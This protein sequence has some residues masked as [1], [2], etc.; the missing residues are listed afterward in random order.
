MFSNNQTNNTDSGTWLDKLGSLFSSPKLKKIL[1]ILGLVLAVA[2][3]VLAFIFF[4]NRNKNGS[5]IVV[6]ENNTE[7]ENQ[8]EN[9]SNNNLPNI[10][11]PDVN[12]GE[13]INGGENGNMD[14]EYLSF[15]DFYQPVSNEIAANINDYNLP[16][17]IKIDG[18]NYYDISRKLNLDLVIDDLNNNGFAVIENPWQNEVSDFYGIYKQL[19]DKQ[20]PFLITSDFII[21]YYQNTIKQTFKGIEESIF[22][23]NLWRINKDLY[24]L[25]KNRYEARLAKVGNVNDAILEGQRMEMAF[26]AVALELLKPS[27]YQIASKGAIEDRTKFTPGD[28]DTFYFNVPPYLRDDVQREVQMIEAAK[29]TAKSPNLLYYRNY[30]DFAVPKEYRGDAKLHNFFLASKWLSSPFP[31]EYKNGTCPDC[32][33][34]QEDWRLSMIAASLISSDFSSRFNLKSS[35]AMIYKLMAYFQGLKEEIDYVDFRDALADV[36]GEDYE[37]EELFDDN[38]KDAVSNLEKLK[39]RLLEYEYAQIMGAV[40]KSKEDNRKLIAFKMLTGA[41]WPNDY[42]FSR[43]TYPAVGS[44][45]GIENY[46]SN[47]TACDRDALIVRCNGFS[48]DIANLVEPISNNEFFERN[49]S[50]DNY[51]REAEILINQLWKDGISHGS[52]YW[53]NINVMETVLNN[54]APMPVFAQSESWQDKNLQTAI[55]AWIN[56]QLPKEDFS[57]NPG[58]NGQNLGKYFNSDQNIYV[59]PN[60]SLIN[61]LIATNNMMEEMFNA[62][63]LDKET[64]L[65]A[66]SIRMIKDDLDMLKAVIEKELK[67]EMI[68]DVDGEDLR[69]FAKKYSIEDPDPND[70]ILRIYFEDV[71]KTVT[72]DLRKPK[73]MVMVHKGGE[74]NMIAVGPVWDYKESR[75]R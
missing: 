40:D 10:G 43:L 11:N 26:F 69:D 39:N 15:G 23:D 52:S 20:I 50:Y 49:T 59:E 37:I 28:A 27:D 19:N 72:L 8:A 36:F 3:L 65:A 58:L 66:Q 7:Q 16:I 22:Y 25:A 41:Y 4:L 17:N 56:F 35:W 62:L 2:L 55:S 53:S 75:S 5:E 6:P 47:L 33:L 30:R 18:I 54:Q 14:I 34:D 63:Q 9:E 64:N 45:N 57:L 51:Q 1:L 38:N 13:M 29:E 73:L 31:I 12:D 21:Y 46:P 74:N 24:E 70:K 61:E 67:G 60:L 44:Y 32:L 71:E 42:I 48:L 68:N